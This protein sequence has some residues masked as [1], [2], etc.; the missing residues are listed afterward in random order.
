MTKKEL[1]LNIMEENEYIHCLGIEMQVLEEGYGKAR[2]PYREAL[3][4]SYKMLHGGCLYS[5]ADIVA[6]MVA[7]MGG[8]YVMTVSGSMNFMA[9]AINTEYV[10][11]EAKEVRRGENLAIFDVRITADD[12]RILD[13]GSFTFFRTGNKV[14][15][16]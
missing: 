2:M 11:C 1:L 4:N 3:T 7:C 8:Q 14:E 16:E 10:Y 13:N 6:G 15:G 5:L 9:P 12:G